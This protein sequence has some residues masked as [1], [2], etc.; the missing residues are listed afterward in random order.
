MN[1]NTEASCGHRNGGDAGLSSSTRTMNPIDQPL[2]LTNTSKLSNLTEKNVVDRRR[3]IVTKLL[4][5]T[6]IM[7]IRNE[8]AETIRVGQSAIITTMV[9]TSNRL[10]NERQQ[11]GNNAGIENK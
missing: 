11:A 8:V 10:V 2:L 5:E 1:E 4:T 6:E 3:A 7:A 9:D